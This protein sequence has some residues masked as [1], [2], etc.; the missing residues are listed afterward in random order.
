MEGREGG[1]ASGGRAGGPTDGKALEGGDV[2]GGRGVAGRWEG[3]GG[4][5]EAAGLEVVACAVVDGD[6]QVAGHAGV[7]AGGHSVGGSVVGVKGGRER[8]VRAMGSAR[9]GSCRVL[10]KERWER[11]MLLA[12]LWSWLDVA[13]SGRIS[14][15]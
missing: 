5:G 9:T 12:T 8:R 7:C 4:E 1:A 15:V 13:R 10:A 11:A 14:F 3:D 6:G 2:D